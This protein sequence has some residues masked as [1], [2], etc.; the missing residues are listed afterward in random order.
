[1]AAKVGTR[2]ASRIRSRTMSVRT[3]GTGS[4]SRMA[5]SAARFAVASTWVMRLV[6]MML[7]VAM[8]SVTLQP[9]ESVEM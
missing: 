6:V 1:M 7:A 3:A 2:V 9:Q 5:T 8:V 4:T